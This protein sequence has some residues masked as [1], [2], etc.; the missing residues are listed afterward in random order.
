MTQNFNNR[1]LILKIIFLAILLVGALFARQYFLELS[2]P[3]GD[4]PVGSRMPAQFNMITDGHLLGLS[5]ADNAQGENHRCFS[6]LPYVLPI[7]I[8][9]HSPHTL[10]SGFESRDGVRPVNIGYRLYHDDFKE[11]KEGKRH[12]FPAPFVPSGRNESSD[13]SI[14]IECPAELGLYQLSVEFVQEGVAWQNDLSQKT[15]FVDRVGLDVKPL[16]Y[17]CD[18]N[19][20]AYNSKMSQ[21]LLD[22]RV[23]ETIKQVSVGAQRLLEVSR[24][25]SQTAMPHY[26]LSNAGSQYPMVWVRDLATIQEAYLN[27]LDFEKNQDSHWSELFFRFQDNEMGVPDWVALNQQH[28]S[29]TYDK[30][31]VSSDQELWLVH[32]IFYAIEKGRLNPEWLE[33]KTRELSHQKHIEMAISWLINNRYSSKHTC[34]TSGHTIDWGDVGPFGADSSTS[35]KIEYGGVEVCST[36]I[37]SLFLQVSKQILSYTDSYPH[38]PFSPQFIKKLDDLKPKITAFVDNE[39]WMKK[40][41]FFKMHYHLSPPKIPDA[42]EK[43]ALGAQVLAYESG[44]L[45]AHQLKSITDAILVRQK[46]YRVSTISGVLFPAYDKGV[47]QNPI[48]QPYE[49][50]NGGQWDWFGGRASIMVGKNNPVLGKKKLE[51]IADKVLKNGTFYEWEHLDGRPGAGPHFRAGAAAFLSSALKLYVDGYEHVSKS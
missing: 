39:L 28:Y 11:P 42:G 33:K 43:F 24:K 10:H 17:P 19:K 5:L 2:E 26:L 34:I 9:N 32:G 41:G 21:L 29:I 18:G 37:Q 7:K 30:N 48:M 16:M 8:I 4:A 35:T 31:T 46:K 20:E 23:P 13:L 3:K 50:Q 25:L 45:Q 22:S 27:Y 14:V 1:Q 44:A 38:H 49:Y 40:E 15:S 47:Y 51:E 12:F 6:G 36:Y